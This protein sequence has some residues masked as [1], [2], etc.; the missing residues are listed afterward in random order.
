MCIV[1]YMM[2]QPDLRDMKWHNSP[3]LWIWNFRNKSDSETQRGSMWSLVQPLHTTMAS[4]ELKR[5]C[6]EYYRGELIWFRT[7]ALQQDP[8][9]GSCPTTTKLSHWCKAL[10]SLQTEEEIV[11][12]SALIGSSVVFTSGY[13]SLV[14]LLLCCVSQWP[15]TKA[16]QEWKV[17]NSDYGND[18]KS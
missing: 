8:I 17:H 4:S 2:E 14:S 16:E 13:Q 5:I 6:I 9:M 7:Q 1:A 15:S 10:S 12:C 18:C 3:K 11:G